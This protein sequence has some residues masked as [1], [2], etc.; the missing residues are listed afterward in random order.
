MSKNI[1][2]TS[3]SL[4]VIILLLNLFA[5]SWQ[6]KNG[7]SINISNTL[8]LNVITSKSDF[9]PFEPIPMTIS[10]EN[11]TPK[12]I[13]GNP[14]IKFERNYIEVLVTN[15]TG[16]KREISQLSAELCKCELAKDKLIESGQK[17]TSQEVLF[18]FHQAF[19]EIG[20]YQIQFFLKNEK[21]EIYI[22]SKLI[23]INVIEPVGDNL[24]AYNAIKDDI[25]QNSF[26]FNGFGD[27]EKYDYL[28]NSFPTTFYGSYSCYFVGL[29]YYY[30]GDYV[31]ANQYLNR[32]FESHL[33]V[34]EAD[35]IKLKKDVDAKLKE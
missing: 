24:I 35:I 4:I 28:S 12:S 2:T 9:L 29:R 25:T 16:E 3:A 33:T 23:P 34:F 5:Y 30:E 8:T 13:I 7:K 21:K 20:K 10:L 19:S 1:F 17:Y 11:N 22:K 27:E 15:E 14:T 26:F 18:N 31:K 32:A 6:I